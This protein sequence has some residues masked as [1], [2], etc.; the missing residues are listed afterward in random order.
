[1]M[2]NIHAAVA[3]M[4]GRMRQLE[5]TANNLSNVNTPGFKRN[6]YF[7][8]ILQDLLSRDVEQPYLN[9]QLRLEERQVV[10][11]SQGVLQKTDNPLDFGFNGAGF[12]VIRSPQ[13][14]AYTRNGNFNR[15]VNGYLVTNDGN[16]VMGENGPIYLPEGQVQVSKDGYIM[17]D[18]QL[19]DR[20]N[21]VRPVNPR[22]I[23]QLGESLFTFQADNIQDNHGEVLQGFLEKSNVN[24]IDAIGEMISLQQDFE[25]NQRMLKAIDGMDRLASNEVGRL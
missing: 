1:M 7:N 10:D 2:R 22:E 24:P 15:D 16:Q 5:I 11:I 25:S 13:G 8:N 17:V 12:F 21:V 4:V 14:I 19:M 18:G 23:S 6:L 9:S 20:F 3:S